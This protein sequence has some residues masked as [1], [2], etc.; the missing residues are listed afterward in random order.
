MDKHPALLYKT[1]VVGVIVLFIGIGIQ[2]AFA[3]SE[4]EQEIGDIEIEIFAGRFLKKDIGF[5]ITIYVRNHKAENITVNKKIEFDYIFLDSRDRIFEFNFT[6]PSGKPMYDFQTLGRLGIKYIT[7]TVNA[8]G[9]IVTRS[10]ISIDT[11][12]IFTD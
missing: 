11:I 2:P 9:T 1:L 6:V 3:I 10:G 7:L 12:I 8:E 5:G 4:L